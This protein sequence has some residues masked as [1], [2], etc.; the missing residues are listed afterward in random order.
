VPRVFHRAWSVLAVVVGTLLAAPSA[1]SQAAG[2]FLF[3]PIE[4]CRVFDTRTGA[5]GGALVTDTPA[6]AGLSSV[7]RL[8]QVRNL[9]GT[10]QIPDH[11]EAITYNVTGVSQ[12][13]LGHLALYPSSVSAP[14]TSS[15]NFPGNMTVANG[16]IVRL[17]RGAQQDLAARL[18]L[19]GPVGSSMNLVLDVT[20]YFAP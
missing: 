17:N 9:P 15:L 20:G 7:T 11:A 1:H 13:Y 3:H 14:T 19:M 8:F 5:Q 4:P 18:V 6:G 10:C 16:G 2:P 12:P